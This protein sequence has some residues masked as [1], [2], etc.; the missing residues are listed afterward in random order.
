VLHAEQVDAVH[1]AGGR[2]IVSPNTDARVIA[3]GVAAG[4]LTMPG[5]GSATEAFTAVQAGAQVLKLFPAGSYGPDHLRAV[6]EVLPAGIEIWAVGG[7]AAENI[8][9]WVAAGANGFGIGGG[10]YRAGRA[11]EE[12]GARARAL[13][14][15]YRAALGA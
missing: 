14:Q 7:V 3:R 11:P 4:M 2:L 13:M 12:V 9:A 6:R 10:I 8:G 5:F 15:A 1:A